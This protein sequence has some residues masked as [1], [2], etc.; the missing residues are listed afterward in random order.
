MQKHGSFMKSNF[1][2]KIDPLRPVTTHECDHDS[3]RKPRLF[4]ITGNNVRPYHKALVS[5]V[6]KSLTNLQASSSGLS[7]SLVLRNNLRSAG[8]G[9]KRLSMVHLQDVINTGF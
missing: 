1:V 3:S 6:W 9:S 8:S 2:L 5:L 4:S 7:F